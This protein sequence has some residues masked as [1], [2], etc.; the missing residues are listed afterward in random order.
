MSRSE[1]LEIEVTPEMVNAAADAMPAGVVDYAGDA[2]LPEDWAP[3]VIRAVLAVALERKHV[4]V[5]RSE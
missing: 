1:N 4:G 3:D 2:W 5:G